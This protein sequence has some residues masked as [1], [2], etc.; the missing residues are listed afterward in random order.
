MNRILPIAAATMLILISGGANHPVRKSPL[1]H[2][3][4]SLTLLRVG[5]DEFPTRHQLTAGA[6]IVSMS[7][8]E[9]REVR[10]RGT[11]RTGRRWIVEL[12]PLGIGGD[13][14]VG[15]ID[16]NSLNDIVFVSYTTSNGNLPNVVV[17]VITF[18]TLGAPVLFRAWGQ[19]D[20]TDT[21]V[22]GLCDI[23][24]NGTTD[25]SSLSFGLTEVAT[26]LIHSTF[27][28]SIQFETHGGESWIRF[29]AASSRI[30]PDTGWI[31]IGIRK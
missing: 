5:L 10:F 27:Q 1:L 26:T 14:F 16:S 4:C 7:A 19:F 2:S 21:G 6:G 25:L 15:D 18:D 20:V 3:E 12:S 28:T 30:L 8:S 17:D 31:W 23:D 11:D 24:K 9:D 13:C 22:K 29:L